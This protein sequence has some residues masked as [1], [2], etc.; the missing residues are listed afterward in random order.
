LQQANRHSSLW[1]ATVSSLL[2]GSDYA[3]LTKAGA[4]TRPLAKAFKEATL[5]F[6]L[7]VMLVCVDYGSHKHLPDSIDHQQF[8]R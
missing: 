4:L 1:K 3:K 7:A 6:I 2:C 8:S 5:V